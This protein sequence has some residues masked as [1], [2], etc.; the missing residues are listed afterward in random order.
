MS[1]GNVSEEHHSGTK[2][3]LC[4]CSSAAVFMCGMQKATLNILRLDFCAMLLDSVSEASGCFCMRAGVF[5][6]S[7]LFCEVVER[8]L[9]HHKR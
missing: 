9:P 5:T 8:R 6:I 1:E 4:M 3:L 7:C 2:H